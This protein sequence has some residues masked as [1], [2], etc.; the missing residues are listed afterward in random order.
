MSKIDISA[1]V[2]FHGEGRLARSAFISIARAKAHAERQGLRVEVLAVLD[3]PSA[4]TTD[5]VASCSDVDFV[6]IRVSYGD[7]GQARN[8]GVGIAR[9]EWVSFLDGDDLWAENWLT[10]AHKA[11]MSDAR[12]IIW[13]PLAVIIFGTQSHLFIHVDTEDADFDLL[14][15]SMS[16]LWASQSFAKKKVYLSVPYPETD[17]NR[18]LG[19][20]DWSWNIATISR[21]YIHKYVPDTVNAYRKKR[22]SLLQQTT[23]RKAMPKATSLFRDLIL[24][25]RGGAP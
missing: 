23:A 7:L 13:H 20:E 10:S 24:G 22:E 5:F 2:N 14:G 15:L 9:G 25:E 17:L 11:G 3:R 18:Q 16:N 19:Y 8:A 12:S 1:I 21:G 6:P 4:E